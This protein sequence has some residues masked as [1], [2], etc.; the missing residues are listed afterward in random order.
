[1]IGRVSRSASEL[2]LSEVES[3][4]RISGEMIWNKD[5]VLS[6]AVEEAFR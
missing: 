1:M 5:V 6:L 4:T 3:G 2:E